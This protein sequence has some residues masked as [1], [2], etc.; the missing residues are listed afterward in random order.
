MIGNVIYRLIG[1]DFVEDVGFVVV[2]CGSVFGFFVREA[3]GVVVEM[4]VFGDGLVGLGFWFG[5]FRE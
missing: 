1:G 5:Y 2:G 4:L 3:V